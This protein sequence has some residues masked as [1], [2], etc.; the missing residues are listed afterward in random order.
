MFYR[1]FYIRNL[2]FFVPCFIKSNCFIMKNLL[3]VAL[4]FLF[5]FQ[6]SSQTLKYKADIEPVLAKGY[7]INSVKILELYYSQNLG[8]DKKPTTQS[9]QYLKD[10]M[11]AVL[12]HIGHSYEKFAKENKDYPTT[13]SAIN[14]INNAVLWYSKVFN[15]YGIKSDTLTKHINLLKTYPQL[16][17]DQNKATVTKIKEYKETF[18]T[19]LARIQVYD[20]NK[21]LNLADKHKNAV[22]LNEYKQA[23]L[24]SGDILSDIERDKLLEEKKKQEAEQKKAE[25]I[26]N[27]QK[28]S[29]QKKFLILQQKCANENVCPNCPVEVAK[30]FRESYY[31]GDIDLMKSL[32]IDYYGDQK[33]FYEKEINL[34]ADLTEDQKAKYSLQFKTQTADYKKSDTLNVVYYTDNE[35]QDFYID[36]NYKT[37]LLQATVFQVINDWDKV[38]LVKF[39]G[40]WYVYRVGGA[41]GGR[42]GNTICNGKFH[43]DSRFLQKE[44]KQKKK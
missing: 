9:I 32:I 24:E 44:I 14:A 42:S 43:V 1:I 18:A 17:T 13:D 6:I 37:T 33:L 8:P 23:C 30:M 11:S 25:M 34:F 26:A 16:W 20:E 28:E 21:A 36:D 41:Y 40:K 19:N 2:A 29:A 7:D 12:L 4:F 3:L 27:Q 5:T 35:K 31:S 22:Y 10:K 15:D 39:Q 38:D